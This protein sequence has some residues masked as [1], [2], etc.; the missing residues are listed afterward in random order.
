M[1][2]SWPHGLSRFPGL[3]LLMTA[4]MSTAMNVREPG[5][6]ERLETSRSSRAFLASDAHAQ[7][8]SDVSEGDPPLAKVTADA[9]CGMYDQVFAINGSGKEVCASL[10]VRDICDDFPPFCAGNLNMTRCAMPQIP[11][12]FGDNRSAFLVWKAIQ[13]TRDVGIT[14]VNTTVDVLENYKPSQNFVDRCKVCRFVWAG[15]KCFTNGAPTDATCNTDTSTNSCF[16]L[17]SS[18]VSVTEDNF[19]LDGHHRWAASRILL[20]KMI[21]PPAT[22]ATLETYRRSSVPVVV[23]SGGGQG[24]GTVNAVTLPV[25]SPASLKRVVESA[26]QCPSLIRHTNCSA[27]SF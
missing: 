9:I 13:A 27:E 6:A 14:Q 24:A 12:A 1:A 15:A 23:P 5:Q 2:I 22:K 20:A 8:S 11:S 3:I 7:K 18:G 16:C 21:L 26:E 17:W 10:P 4:S 19:I 25:A